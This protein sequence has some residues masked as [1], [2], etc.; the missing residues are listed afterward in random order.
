M[1]SAL[2]IRIFTCS[3]FIAS[4]VAESCCWGVMWADSWLDL[5]WD[6]PAGVVRCGL[7]GTFPPGTN[8]TVENSKDANGNIQAVTNLTFG[9]NTQPFQFR[10]GIDP[11]SCDPLPNDK[12]VTGWE[13]WGAYLFKDFLIMSQK[14]EFCNRDI[15]A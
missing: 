13:G 6:E 3:A 7:S 12:V 14:M 9:S 5:K 11:S 2:F 10:I 1:R 4:A 8:C 15:P